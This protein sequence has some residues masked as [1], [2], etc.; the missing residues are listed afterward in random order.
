MAYTIVNGIRFHDE[1]AGDGPPVLL[2]NGL[3]SPAASWALQGEG[4]RA[5]AHARIPLMPS[6]RA[7]LR[8]HR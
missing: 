8:A 5:V 2:I 7:I 3:G 4:A 1:V 6:L